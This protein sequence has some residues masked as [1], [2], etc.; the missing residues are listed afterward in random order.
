MVEDRGITNSEEEFI[1]S[2]E[3][4]NTAKT[5]IEEA[6]K[7]GIIL[8]VMGALAIRIHSTPEMAEL[9]KKLGRFAGKKHTFTAVAILDYQK[10]RPKVQ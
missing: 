8:R 6:Q 7:E 10:P 2:E 3:F 1:P 5:L 4:I 9:H